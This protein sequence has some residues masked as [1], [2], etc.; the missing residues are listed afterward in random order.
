MAA[1]L[2]AL[3]GY[4]T[5]TDEA[6][7]TYEGSLAQVLARVLNGYKFGMYTDNGAM[8][9]T[10]TGTANAPSASPGGPG[11]SSAQIVRQLSTAATTAALQPRPSTAAPQ[12]IPSIVAPQPIPSNGGV[13]RWFHLRQLET[14][15][16]VLAG[17]TLGVPFSFG[18][19]AIKTGCVFDSSAMSFRGLFRLA[20]RSLAF[21]LY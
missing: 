21:M 9:V 15:Y 14:F 1:S 3:N 13:R 19:S 20:A 8:A 4:K 5:G 18:F 11:S 6:R 10:V 2:L 7:G 17:V 12:P 16:V